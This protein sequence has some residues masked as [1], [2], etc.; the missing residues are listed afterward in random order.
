MKSSVTPLC[1]ES[2]RLHSIW[3]E[4]KVFSKP[5]KPWACLAWRVQDCRPL[6][7]L[8]ARGA[9]WNVVSPSLRTLIPGQETNCYEGPLDSFSY[10]YAG[11]VG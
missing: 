1:D 4:M 2:L 11:T 10:F 9:G 6:G 7:D 3:N 5:A 8:H